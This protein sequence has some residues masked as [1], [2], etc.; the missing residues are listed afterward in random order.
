MPRR[1]LFRVLL[2][3][4]A[5]AVIV[6]AAHAQVRPSTVEA[7]GEWVGEMIHDSEIP[8]LAL[9]LVVGDSTV[10]LRGFGLREIEKPALVDEHTAFQVASLTKSMTAT[11]LAILVDEGRIEW[12]DPVH[13]HLPEFGLADEYVAK[14]LTVRD[15]LAMRS[16]I[17]G[18][19]S[20]A[21]DDSLSPPEILARMHDLQA[22]RFRATYGDAPNLMYFLAGEIVRE[23]SGKDY[24]EVL[25][26]RIFAPLGMV[27]STTSLHPSAERRENHGR[28]GR[29][30]D[31]IGPGSVGPLQP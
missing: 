31:G 12:D 21:F 20:L 5:V 24:R 28:R 6:P 13:E 3:V 22:P 1:S 4:A 10:L 26:E 15:A 8:G 23:V 19:D 16:G 27:E 25:L 7:M 2:T 29:N 11:L 14:R 30:D 18:G 9:G 17:Q